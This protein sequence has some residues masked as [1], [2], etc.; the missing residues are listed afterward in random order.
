MGTRKGKGIFVWLVWLAACQTPAEPSHSSQSGG[1]ADAIAAASDVV[2]DATDGQTNS[3]GTCMR[4]GIP[5]NCATLDLCKTFGK[6]T[7]R[8]FP[9]CDCVAATDEDCK[10]SGYCVLLGRC[11]AKDGACV[12]KA[13]AGCGWFWG[14]SSNYECLSVGIC[15]SAA[16]ICAP[17]SDAGCMASYGCASSG[18]CHACGP[19]GN[20]PIVNGEPQDG[21]YALTDEDCARSGY[22]AQ[23][24]GCAHDGSAP[25]AAI[26]CRPRN[27][28]DCSNSWLCKSQGRCGFVTSAA[29]GATGC[30]VTAE[31]CAASLGCSES[32]R[33]SL[34]KHKAYG[35]PVCEATSDGECAAS[36]GCKRWGN[37]K[38]D[39]TT[40]SCQW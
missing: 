18:A 33:C 12:R 17:N 8:P 14:D 39:P 21:C 2:D 30:S 16:G 37:C 22:C 31:G 24:G 32:G 7:Q 13:S 34:V 23:A 5:L 4:G 15:E 11:Q 26:P 1:C 36:L 10:G 29:S 9:D 38:W 19:R 40:R 25:S 3:T 6:C 27:A 28:A 20:C 35:Y